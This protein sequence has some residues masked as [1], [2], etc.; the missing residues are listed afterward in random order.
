[1]I[2]SFYSYKGGVGRS[3]LCANLASY[4]CHRADKKILL[5]DW[6]LEA[7][8]LH[9]FFNKG[10]NDINSPGT[11]ELLRNY[12]NVMRTKSNVTENDYPVFLPQSF[13]SLVAGEKGKIDLI[14]AG[15]YNDNYISKVNDFD[16]REFY[17]LLDGQAYVE[18]LKEWFKG[19][20]YDFIFVDSRT[21]IND[22]S[23]IC[24]IQLPDVNVVVMAAN[25]QNI[26]GCKRIISGI[27]NSEY[28]QRGYRKGYV[29]PILS[30]INI[31][32]KDFDTWATK[33]TENFNQLL[34]TLDSTIEPPFIEEIFKEFYL[35][36]T[37]L[38]D[39]SQYSVGENLLITDK[40]KFI[41]RN[42]F[43]AKYATL[44]E[45]I[46]SLA[47][48]SSIRI[49]NQIDNGTWIEWAKISKANN[50]FEKASIAF[51][52]SGEYE[53]S[54]SLGGTYRSFLLLGDEYSIKGDNNKAIDCY[55]KAIEVNPYHHKA[56]FGMGLAYFSQGNKDM[57]V[58]NSPRS[59]DYLQNAIECFEKSIEINPNFLEAWSNLGLAYYMKS[60]YDK[61]IEC[62]Q[63]LLRIDPSLFDTYN[64]IGNAYYEK[65]DKDTA[66]E[67]YKKATE[68]NPSFYIAFT[69]MGLA[70]STKGDEYM[71]IDCY[72]KA[73]SIKPDYG[74]AVGCYGFAL[75]QIGKINESENYIR[76][77]IELGGMDAGNMNLGHIYYVKGDL[78]KAFEHYTMSY[79]AYVDKNLFC[80]EMETDF[81][82]LEQYSVE[83]QE[84]EALYERIT[85]QKYPTK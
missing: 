71:G 8:G 7:P 57:L 47:I 27:L 41:P 14:P 23:G 40:N 5:W 45:Y 22:Y 65:G 58:N 68:L 25:D 31:N 56:F 82:Y 10:M 43:A 61:S 42:S 48:N 2:I 29:F 85:K 84:Y 4:L 21:G 34:H 26:D 49:V 12:T 66:I 44:G 18:Y 64:T 3:Q 72:K 32:H 52:K 38:S 33:F 69:N 78:E 6:D 53:K 70:F 36:K 20:D 11:I 9:Y 77:H 73:L 39:D 83:R 62:L 67:Y 16:W 19:L 63:N 75:M 50:N 81:K 13:I 24:N 30:R 80:Q 28:T 46:Q 1:M 51:E 37:L 54:V 79:N 74:V 15:S 60:D 35:D 55:Q 59:I 17:M 76:K